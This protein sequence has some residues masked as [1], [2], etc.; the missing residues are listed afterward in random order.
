MAQPRHLGV[1]GLGAY[2]DRL[3]PQPG[4]DALE[5]LDRRRMSAWRGA[6]DQ[7][8]ANDEACVRSLDALSR[9]S[10]HRLPTDVANLG[11]QRVLEN[12]NDSALHATSIGDQHI[13]PEAMP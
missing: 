4:D 11:S 7:G 5:L 1:V 10:E 9:G 12:G 2:D 13:V 6:D 8:R 3:H